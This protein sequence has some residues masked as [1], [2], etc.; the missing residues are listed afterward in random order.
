MNQGYG[1]LLESKPFRAPYTEGMI[2]PS[3]KRQ[4]HP[5]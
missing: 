4:Q 1:I 5:L 2:L 3:P